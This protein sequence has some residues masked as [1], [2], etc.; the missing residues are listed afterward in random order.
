MV[1]KT[2]A[3]WLA[4]LILFLPVTNLLGHGGPQFPYQA[5]GDTSTVCGG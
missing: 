5:A 1:S 3:G 2:K 4:F